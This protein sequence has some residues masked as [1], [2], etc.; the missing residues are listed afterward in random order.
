MAR[1]IGQKIRKCFICDWQV[2]APVE[3]TLAPLN[4]AV[5]SGHEVEEA[6]AIR[7]TD[8]RDVAFERLRP[9]HSAFGQKTAP[10]HVASVFEPDIGKQC[11]SSERHVYV[12]AY[13][14]IKVVTRAV[15]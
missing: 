14:Q 8:T 3:Q 5:R 12:G 4:R 7:I 15:G 9:G 2:H 13:N 10:E 1:P 11:L 6:M